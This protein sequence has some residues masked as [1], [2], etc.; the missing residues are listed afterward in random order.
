MNR[1]RFISLIEDHFRELKIDLS[2]RALA[3]FLDP[4]YFNED[5]LSTLADDVIARNVETLLREITSL[6][7][8]S[9]ERRLSPTLE[10]AD[11][12][13]VIQARF[14]RL[15]PFCKSITATTKGA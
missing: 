9:K 3:A 2:E 14:C 12:T 4:R 10:A 11:V 13:P 5:L 8:T 15:P 7:E 1:Q 6:Y